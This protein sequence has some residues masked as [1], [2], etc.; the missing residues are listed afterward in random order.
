MTPKTGQRPASSPFSSGF[1][2]DV[3]PLVHR[4]AR[5][6]AI[7]QGSPPAPA[8]PIATGGRVPPQATRPPAT[9]KTPAAQPNS[10][11]TDLVNN[12]HEVGPDG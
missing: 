11:R 7:N 2:L 8:G 12:V 9:P 3:R 6:G 10:A 4:L 1:R 5:G